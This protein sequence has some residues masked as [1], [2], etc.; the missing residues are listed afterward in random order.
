[1]SYLLL[2]VVKPECTLDPLGI[3]REMDQSIPTAR[4]L[5]VNNTETKKSAA[6]PGDIRRSLSSGAAKKGT[7]FRKPP[8]TRAS[9]H[10]HWAT[11][12]ANESGDEDVAPNEEHIVDSDDEDGG[13]APNWPGFDGSIGDYWDDTSSDDEDLFQ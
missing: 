11:A 7:S 3:K 6:H 10:I 9:N 1:M 13:T 5:E 8:T 2:S 12:D 4:D